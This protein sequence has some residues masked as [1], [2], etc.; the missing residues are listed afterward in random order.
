M[1]PITIQWSELDQY[2]AHINFVWYKPF[3]LFHLE[4]DGKQAL[5]LNLDAIESGALI[6]L[7]HSI[8]C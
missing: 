1:A 3:T 6:F 2:G 5:G 7:D 8:L 4:E